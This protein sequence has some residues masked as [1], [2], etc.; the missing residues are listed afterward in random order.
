MSVTTRKAKNNHFQIWKREYSVPN[1]RN[2]F[3]EFNF[4][5]FIL[6]IKIQVKWIILNNS[7]TKAC[8]AQQ[9]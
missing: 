2:L 1:Q 7:H 3:G 4:Y 5:Y 9:A 8:V 6:F